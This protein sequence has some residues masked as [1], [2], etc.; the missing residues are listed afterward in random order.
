MIH[1]LAS[2]R[3][4]KM[5]AAFLGWFEHA[6]VVAMN[7]EWLSKGSLLVVAVLVILL[8]VFSAKEAV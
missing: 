8:I 7:V 1:K 6:G 4:F 3:L 2:S 5:L